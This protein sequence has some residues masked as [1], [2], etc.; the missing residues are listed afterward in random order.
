MTTTQRVEYL[1][2]KRT[3][4]DAESDL[5]SGHYL[6]NTKASSLAPNRDIK[7]KIE[8][9]KKMIE[10][11]Q[12]K[13]ATT[14][15]ELARLLILIEKQQTQQNS[16]DQTRF[17]YTL[18]SANYEE[19]ITTLSKQLLETCWGRGY[20]TLFFDGIFLQDNEGT[21]SAS[22]ELRNSTY[23]ALVK[24]DGTTFS[25]T[26]PV[27]FKL[28]SDTHGNGND[29]FS[30]EN[31]AIFK[32]DKKA[33]LAIEL[34]LPTGSSTGLLSL[35]A[36]DLETQHIAAY[37]LIK[38]ADLAAALGIEAD[39]LEDKT[40][41]QLELR[42][43]TNTLETLSNLSKPYTFELSSESHT[44]EVPELLTYTL[45]QNTNLQLTDSDFI[46]R[47]YGESLDMPDAWSGPANASLTIETGEDA[48]TYQ[49][50][51]VANASQRVIPSGTLTLS[52]TAP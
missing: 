29:I 14:Q 31:A 28:K 1:R 7:P 15:E 8:R 2:L 24:A 37:Q 33:L 50:N 5:K 25:V 12:L 26:T 30:Y 27:G 11:A 43:D 48:D 9:G 13:I 45:L 44:T 17:D 36:I 47:A 46:L 39:G 49:L 6:A 51:A 35:Q 19:A 40:P 10:R 22:P 32:D 38:I 41:N 18:E 34:I 3:I 4:E 20:Q 16:M 52:Q 21:Q 23:D 42:D